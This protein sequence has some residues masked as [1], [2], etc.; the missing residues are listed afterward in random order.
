MRVRGFGEIFDFAVP[1]GKRMFYF[2]PIRRAEFRFHF[3]H[4]AVVEFGNQIL[5]I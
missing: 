3:A 2:A 5:F 1:R 4:Q